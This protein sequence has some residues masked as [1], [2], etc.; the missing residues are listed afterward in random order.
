M[1]YAKRDSSHT[2]EIADNLL[3]QTKQMSSYLILILNA[4]LFIE[5]LF[6]SQWPRSS[7]KVSLVVTNSHVADLGH[8]T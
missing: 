2:R 6:I 3:Y 7:E 8:L 4:K 5:L 1:I